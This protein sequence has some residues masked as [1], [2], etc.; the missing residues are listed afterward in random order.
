M[1][2]PE[3]WCISHFVAFLI[4]SAEHMH[5]EAN[6]IMLMLNARHWR[7]GEKYVKFN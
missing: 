7:K 4:L 2:L 5:Q 3:P 6:F 1:A